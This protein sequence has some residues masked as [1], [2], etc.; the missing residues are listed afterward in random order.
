VNDWN[1]Q[2]ALVED[3]LHEEHVRRGHTDE[4]IPDKDILCMA[5]CVRRMRE[6]LDRYDQKVDDLIAENDELRDRLETAANGVNAVVAIN[7]QLGEQNEELRKRLEEPPFA[8]GAYI[9]AK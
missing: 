2:C 5:Y 9:P 3:Y 4:E 6:L 1:A 7:R 8:E